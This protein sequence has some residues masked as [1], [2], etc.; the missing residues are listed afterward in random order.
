MSYPIKINFETEWFPILLILASFGLAWYFYA[1]FPTVVVSHWNFEGQP[2]G[3]MGKLWAAVLIPLMLVF[4]YL[5][6]LVLPMLDPM[7]DRY[8]EFEKIYRTFRNLL[9]FALLVIYEIIG[10]ANLGYHI[11]IS[12][13]I[14]IIVGLLFIVMGFLMP[15]IKRNWF[16]GI[17]TPWAISSENVWDKTQALGG[18]LFMIFGV[19]VILTPFLGR[20]L[21]IILFLTG[22]AIAV[23]GSVIYSYILYRREI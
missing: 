18:K 11:S 15:K 21:G 6:L 7:K 13:T 19:V 12:K 8:H 20:V 4:V 5:L 14:P 2:D 17:R 10:L 9:L 22:L 3:Y 16:V 23:L 1:H